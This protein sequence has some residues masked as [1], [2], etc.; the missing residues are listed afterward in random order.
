MLLFLTKM[1]R[2]RNYIK[3]ILLT[4][5][6][7]FSV[8]CKISQKH[9]KEGTDK[10][11]KT[12]SIWVVINFL[13][14]CIQKILMRAC[15]WACPSVAFSF[16]CVH[17]CLQIE[18]N[19]H[20]ERCTGDFLSSFPTVIKWFFFHLKSYFLLRLWANLISVHLLTKIV[21][22]LGSLW[23]YNTVSKAVGSV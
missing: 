19:T 11:I 22:S 1:P 20:T 7:F 16:C 10:K 13:Y 15:P 6:Y 5:T 9:T 8:H 4:F 3:V 17:T 21:T 12:T 23:F 14:H 2:Q 18:L